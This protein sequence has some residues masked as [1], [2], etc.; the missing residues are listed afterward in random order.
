M[1]KRPFIARKSDPLHGR[2]QVPG[3]KSISHRAL[4]F[5]LLAKGRSTITGLLEGDDVLATAEAM[6]ALG[7]RVE[8]LQNG[9]WQVDGV[10][11][12]AL[13]EPANVLDMGNSGTAARLLIG[14]LST[15]PIASVLTGD[16]SLRGRPMKRV[17]DPL[18]SIG[19]GYQA[20]SGGRLPLSI[21]GNGQAA[22]LSHR[23]SVASAQ[24]KSALLLAALNIEGTSVVEDP[25]STRDHT[26][27]M[28]R[29]FGAKVVVD[30]L[31][32]GTRI[33]LTGKPQLKA[34]DVTVP[35]DPSSAAFALVAALIVP[36]SDITL[37]NI[38]MNVTRTG[39]FDALGQMGADIHVSN[40]RIEGGEPVADLGVRYGPL[41]GVD[42][43][44]DIVPRMVDEFPILAVAAANASGTS[45][46]RG[47]E[48][49][50]VKESDRLAAIH[51][52]LIAIGADARI[53]GDDLIIEGKGAG[54]VPG[55]NS[56]QP[57][58]TH[59]DHRIAMSFLVA[60]L[61]SERPVAVD[62]TAAIAT[63]FPNFFALMEGLGARFAA[64]EGP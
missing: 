33:T 1:T 26:E 16:G 29:H 7:G 27:N 35:G 30:A 6:R 17:T 50:R 9:C 5:S 34:S 19:A 64:S 47:L 11:I 54:S 52:G 58:T 8:R 37:P 12:G 20:R 36:G 61:A 28:L 60:G 32:T 63:S 25:F 21:A 23:L 41:T 31:E 14:L 56:T 15:H 44:E 10:G 57:V 4:M 39:L 62:D 3:D 45:V 48:E 18:A 40:H 51:A 38:C 55:G 13:E 24:V 2:A 59:F 53:D 43:G 46:F 49:L 22:P 42:L